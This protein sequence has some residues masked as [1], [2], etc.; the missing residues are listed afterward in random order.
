M[1]APT[2]MSPRSSSSSTAAERVCTIRSP[3]LARVVLVSLVV[4]GVIGGAWFAG[5]ML[6][7]PWVADS[8]LVEGLVA[9]IVLLNG[10]LLAASLSRA[11]GCGH[12]HTPD[13]TCS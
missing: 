1:T 8:L 6:A 9:G 12:C 2:P 7:G 5:V 11:L 3:V 10:V 4:M 13:C